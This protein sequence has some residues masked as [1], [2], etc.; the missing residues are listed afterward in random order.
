MVYTDKNGALLLSRF[1]A[2]S[3]GQRALA[4]SKEILLSISDRTH[5]EHN[6]GHIDFASDGQLYLCVGDMDSPG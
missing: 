1:A 6:C 3:D 5:D 4:D 2:T